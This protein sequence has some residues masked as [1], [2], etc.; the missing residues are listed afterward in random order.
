[1]RTPER[2]GESGCSSTRV[3]LVRAGSRFDRGS[4]WQVVHVVFGDLEP[5][6]VI[7]G[8]YAVDGY[9][10]IMPATPPAALGEEYVGDMTIGGMDEN[11]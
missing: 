7:D 5:D 11:S 10:H 4:G 2:C 3:G 6:P 1:M 8:A 9:C